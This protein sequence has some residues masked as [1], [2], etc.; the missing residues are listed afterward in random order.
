MD[1][2]AASS[3][4][5]ESGSCDESQAGGQEEGGEEGGEEESPKE[6]DQEEDTSNEVSEE[7]EDSEEAAPPPP[8]KRIKSKASASTG[9]RSVAPSAAGKI[10]HK[11]A[12]ASVPDDGRSATTPSETPTKAYR[13]RGPGS[14][15]KKATTEGKIPYTFDQAST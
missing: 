7:E 14:G 4:D 11:T 8:R 15:R 13:A 2:K 3:S 6:C 1:F 10:K 12:P 9:T 5:D